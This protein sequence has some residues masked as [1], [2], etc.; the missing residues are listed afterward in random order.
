MTQYVSLPD[1]VFNVTLNS[2]KWGELGR[3]SDGD[4]G[5]LQTPE[6]IETSLDKQHLFIQKYWIW[7]G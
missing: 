3:R 4:S 2:E 1:I 5:N 7:V 6:S